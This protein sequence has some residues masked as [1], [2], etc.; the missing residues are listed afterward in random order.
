MN[1]FSTT[2]SCLSPSSSVGTRTPF[3]AKA[4]E[5]KRGK[6]IRACVDCASLGFCYHRR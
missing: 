2:F 1:R 5:K 4:K 3:E 6:L